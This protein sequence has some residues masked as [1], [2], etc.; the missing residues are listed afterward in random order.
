MGT[1]H[2]SKEKVMLLYLSRFIFLVNFRLSLSEHNP[3][4]DER[5]CYHSCNSL[6]LPSDQFSPSTDWVVT[7][8][9]IQ[10]RSSASL[11]CRRPTWLVLASAGMSTLWYCPSS[12][13]SAD[14]GV[15][16]AVICPEGWFWRGC[17]GVW[18][19]RTIQVS[20]SWQLPEEV[21]VDLQGS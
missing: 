15:A 7:R 16:H 6:Y 2:K 1:V 3:F 17:R 12:I 9:T 14:H 18:Y 13:F 11:F 19:A 20:V 8:G 10:Q 21:P 5:L 4:R